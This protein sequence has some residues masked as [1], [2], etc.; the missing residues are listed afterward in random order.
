MVSALL[1]A[2][3][4]ALPGPAAAG[5][6]VVAAAADL[7]F[8]LGEIAE[9]FARETGQSVRLAFGSS[10]NFARQI[11]QG[12][13]FELFLSADEAYVR[14]L[15][16]KSLTADE[17]VVYGVGRLVIFAPLGSPLRPDAELGDLRA[18]LSDGRLKRLAIA[19]PDHAPYG[20]AAREA[21][22]RAGLWEALQGRLV[23]GENA[24]QAAQFALSGAA[25]GGLIPYALALSPALAARGTAVLLPADWHAPLIQRMVLIA[26]AGPT[27]RAFYAFLQGPAARAVFERFGFVLPEPTN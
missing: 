9:L 7:G 21:L 17:G 14:Q 22:I 8:V 3:L 24:S 1:V 18:A 20:R 26:N 16:E 23:L 25:E 11:A 13:P 19:N 2:S 5:A 15:K 12:G 6:P 27:A 10:G 4:A